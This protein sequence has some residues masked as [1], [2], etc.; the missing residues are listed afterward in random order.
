MFSLTGMLEWKKNE[1]NFSS[2]DFSNSWFIL[3]LNASFHVAILGSFN[4]GSLV[5]N[6]SCSVFCHK[7]SPKTNN[8]INK[9]DGH[10]EQIG[11][12]APW[13]CANWS[14]LL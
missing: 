10:C 8:L 7:C 2:V 4:L 11:G 14:G 1:K 3:L 6:C 5:V 12:F 9:E 13:I